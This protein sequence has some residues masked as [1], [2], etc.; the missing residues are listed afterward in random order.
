MGRS[1]LNLLVD[2]AT[3]LLALAMT[4]TGLTIRW[5]LPRHTG[6]RLTIWGGDRH[7]WGDVHY[8]LAWILAGLVVVHVAMHW[9]WVCSIVRDRAARLRRVTVYGTFAP[10]RRAYAGHW[11]GGAALMAVGALL[12]GF[13]WLA[14]RSIVESGS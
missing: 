14:S 7:A 8:Y 5:L 12:A 6:G 9:K 4:I 1:S 13:L 11:Y 10:G 3:F 2:I